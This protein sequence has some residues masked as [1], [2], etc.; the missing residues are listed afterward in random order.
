MSLTLQGFVH[1]IR[2]DGTGTA[3]VGGTRLTLET[4]IRSFLAGDTAEEIADAYALPLSDAY[5]TI[6]YYLQH[7]TEVDEY[8]RTVET[9]EARVAQLIQERSN[10]AALRQK[11]LARAATTRAG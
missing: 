5:A 6:S 10:P 3:R 1:P 7:R 8:L 11:L 4:V 9:E 2:I